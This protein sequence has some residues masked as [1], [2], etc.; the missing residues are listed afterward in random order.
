[1]TLPELV[2]ANRA[3]AATEQMDLIN[4]MQ[5]NPARSIAVARPARTSVEFAL[6]RHENF[7]AAQAM[8]DALN[9]NVDKCI[10]SNPRIR[11]D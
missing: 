7:E 3:L 1:M 11:R 5:T 4:A 6:S 9:E 10:P 2:A 8:L